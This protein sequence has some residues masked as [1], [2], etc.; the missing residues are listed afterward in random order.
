MFGA[1]TNGVFKFL[2]RLWYAK[3][4]WRLHNRCLINGSYLMKHSTEIDVRGLCCLLPLFLDNIAIT[5]NHDG[6]RNKIP[7]KCPSGTLFL[8]CFSCLSFLVVY[9]LVTFAFEKQF[10][11]NKLSWRLSPH[12][13]LPF[14]HTK[15]ERRWWKR[16]TVNGKQWDTNKGEEEW[17]N[18]W[19]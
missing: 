18:Q 15:C 1:A 12:A 16:E 2:I 14:F 8:I 10:R 19:P 4:K 9:Q 5:V 13:V 11:F 17:N 6:R 3:M 7:F